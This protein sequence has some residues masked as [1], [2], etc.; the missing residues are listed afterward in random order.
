MGREGWLKEEGRWI[1]WNFLEILYIGEQRK[2]G[3]IV[4]NMVGVNIYHK[5]I[6][7]IYKIK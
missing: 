5:L 3:E 7:H 1:C 2:K 6:R 4:V